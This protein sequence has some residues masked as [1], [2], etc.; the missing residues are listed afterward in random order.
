M[1]LSW[2]N[3]KFFY[4]SLEIICDLSD[5]FLFKD[6]LKLAQTFINY[7]ISNQTPYL[8]AYKLT[9]LVPGANYN[10]SIFTNRVANL[11]EMSSSTQSQSVN[12]IAKLSQAA[13]ISQKIAAKSINSVEVELA[14]PLGFYDY[15][16]I[17]VVNIENVAGA[18]SALAAKTHIKQVDWRR[19]QA[20]KGAKAIEAFMTKHCRVAHIDRVE[21]LTRQ[22]SDYLTYLAR[23]Q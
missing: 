8:T 2:T 20:S 14:P 13:L 1:E 17:D 16:Q 18:V 15:F 3:P 12:Q 19:E 5:D 6:K 4:D 21:D 22:F 9:N 23:P 7:T 10:C 11:A